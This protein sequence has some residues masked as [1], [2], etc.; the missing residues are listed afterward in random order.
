MS[1][2][3]PMNIL[4]IKE[5]DSSLSPKDDL[6]PACHVGVV[7]DHHDINPSCTRLCARNYPSGHGGHS[8]RLTCGSLLPVF[9]AGVPETAWA[10]K[11]QLYYDVLGDKRTAISEFLILYV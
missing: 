11:H 1:S 6:L 5:E 8:L 10:D 9:E 3:K 4:S 2:I 7:N